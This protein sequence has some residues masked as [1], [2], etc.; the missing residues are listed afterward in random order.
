MMKNT[1]FA[2]LPAVQMSN[3]ELR[4][5]IIP[6]LGGKIVE[7][8]DLR[9]GREWLALNKTAPFRLPKYG[10]SFVGDYDYGG[11][12]ECFPTITACRYPKPPWQGAPLPDHGEIWS[13]P[14]ELHQEAEKIDLVAQGVNL[15]YE[16]RRT[17]ELL[18]NGGIHFAYQVTN[19]SPYPM[20]FLWSSH[21]L[22]SVH[23]GMQIDIPETR[24]HVDT[25]ISFPARPGDVIPWPRYRG[26]DLNLVPESS[27]GMAVK[28]FSD[29]LS[30]GWAVLSD[31]NDGA[32]LR[33]DF[34]PRAIT[35]LGLWLNYG[36]WT[37]IPGGKPYFNLAIEPCIGETDNLE[38][39]MG[40]GNQVGAL[41]AHQ[42]KV[43]QL[44][45]TLS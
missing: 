1:I 14:W 16:F 6:E 40:E 30:E 35:H 32:A 43:W 41:D 11:F 20:E 19:K 28:L 18:S 22:L 10:A 42:V 27:A 29:R 31:P 23:P 45:I 7:M 39:G 21:P 25:A 33:F 26:L 2:G 8:K 13:L 37:G 3:N 4:L 36:G 34:D 17:I 24:L 44:D 12:D 9:R 38:T 15:P 5:T